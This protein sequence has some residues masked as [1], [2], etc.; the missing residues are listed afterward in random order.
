MQKD[1]ACRIPGVN[2]LRKNNQQISNDVWKL[3]DWITDLK[4]MKIELSPTASK[5]YTCLFD[6]KLPTYLSM[7]FIRMVMKDVIFPQSDIDSGK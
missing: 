3:M 5:V 7:N 2:K 4:N 1:V 6:M